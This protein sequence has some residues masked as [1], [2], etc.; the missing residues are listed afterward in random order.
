MLMG[1][2]AFSYLTPG[3][4]PV[5]VYISVWGEVRGSVARMIT[6]FL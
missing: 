6:V 5:Q 1:L 3:R 2:K 4:I